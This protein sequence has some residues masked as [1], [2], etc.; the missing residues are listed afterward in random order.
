LIELQQK[1][2]PIPPA[3]V[4]PATCFRAHLRSEPV[5]G[6]WETYLGEPSLENASALRGAIAAAPLTPKLHQ[7]LLN[8][9]HELGATVAMRSSALDED[10]SSRSF[11]GQH[12]T[13]L[14]VGPDD[15]SAALRRCWASLF[16]ETAIAYRREPI[17]PSTAMAVLV[18]TL[19][20]P[21]VSGVLFTINPLN[22]SWREMVVEATWGLGEPLVSGQVSPHWYLVRRPRKSPS[23]VQ[24]IVA[25]VRLN[26]LQEDLPEI[27]SYLVR[28][29][30]RIREA[31]TP[32]RLNGR[33]TLERDQL[34]KLCRIG[35]RVE[36]IMGSPRDIEWCLDHDGKFHLLQARPITA[37]A[38]L[39]PRKDIL[40]TRRFIGERWPEPATPMGWSILAPILDWFIG[41]PRTQR[42][43]LGGGPSLRLV[44]GH[45]YINAT[46]F[47]HLLFKSPG[48]PPPRFLLD[49]IPPDEEIT[50]RN[51]FSSKPSFNVY[52]SILRETFVERR[53]RRFAWSPLT[54]HK[55]WD[56][57]RDRL[58]EQLDSL[59][60]EAHSASASVELVTVHEEWIR[61]Y[62]KIHVISLLY[63]N[64]FYHALESTITTAL[65]E[66]AH[67]LLDRLASRIDP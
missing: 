56:R 47:R 29:Q 64:I 38:S 10:S 41:Y 28:D 30:G 19:I 67:W 20:E 52:G 35:L 39:P 17:G 43:Y 65:P 9:V 25:R 26:V 37:K 12:L 36:S 66:E 3:F 22:G 27:P 59:K 1:G 58:R 57:F 62:I 6:A 4:L 61:D 33:R 60:R 32:L 46:I 7:E 34:F 8:C 23:S 5:L 24:R 31:N 2:L 18:Q 40:W 11:A 45:P 42:R 51:R 55:R 44:D 16:A 53:W 15:A 14:S 49:M 63:A 13:E 48:T 21:A 54:N 50:W